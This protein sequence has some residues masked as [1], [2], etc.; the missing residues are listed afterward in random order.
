MEPGRKTILNK[1]KNATRIH[2]VRRVA[3][4]V[5][6]VC[7]WLVLSGTAGRSGE[8]G[9]N[10]LAPNREALVARV[11]A[12][13]VTLGQVLS[14]WGPVWHEVRAQVMAGTLP[15]AAADAKLQTAWQEALQN[16]IRD[17]IFYQEAVR[18]EERTFQ[19]YVDR[20]VQM[21]AR[22][23]G[24]TPPRSSVER[25]LRTQQEEQLRGAVNRMVQRQ[26]QAAGG[27]ENLRRMLDARQISY[28]A[29]KNE[30]TRKGRTLQY[31][32]NR[33]DPFGEFQPRPRDILTYYREN[34]EEFTVPGE[35]VFRHILF[36]NETRG[37]DDAAYQAAGSVW[38]AITDGRLTFE[39]AA[40]THSDDPLSA[41][42]GG[43]ETGVSTDPDREAWLA[44]V[45]HALR[46]ETPGTLA[47]ILLSSRGAHL[48]MLIETRPGERIPFETAQ[49]TI[50]ERMRNK[51]WEER[52]DDLYTQIR[53]K[54][55]VE[56]LMPRFPTPFSLAQPPRG[57]RPTRR[58]GMG[59][60]AIGEG[61]WQGGEDA[62]R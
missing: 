2:G 35:V 23:R 14:L 45:R 1:M 62:T 24:S 55:P 4:V 39:E 9:V 5:G 26:I 25:T 36:A 48:G 56:I 47:P 16:Q 27:F 51:R 34:P 61:D 49:D 17:E 50:A 60:E 29:W 15:A 54:V 42:R 46:E 20:Y 31:L 30:L 13:S 32:H 28:S 12:G 40:Q 18:E 33:I 10:P 7:V 52:T 22:Q 43:L 41:A 44:D 8:E 6:M 58:I 53:E 11:G 37:G 21:M 19:S 57:M 3:A 38:Q 59:A